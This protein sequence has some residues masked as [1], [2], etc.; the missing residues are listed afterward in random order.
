[1]LNNC[2]NQHQPNAI[3]FSL[4]VIDWEYNRFCS[5]CRV[6]FFVRQALAWRASVVASSTSTSVWSEKRKAPLLSSPR[7]VRLQ[8]YTESLSSL[9]ICVGFSFK[10]FKFFLQSRFK[11][12]S[13]KTLVGAPFQLR[14]RRQTLWAHFIV[15]TITTDCPAT[16]LWKRLVRALQKHQRSSLALTTFCFALHWCGTDPQWL[17]FLL[18][19]EANVIEQNHQ[20]N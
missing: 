20:A 17:R 5:P 18:E 13:Q 8:L 9:A 2:G 15:V 7:S 12:K 10:S 4:Y 1:M 14:L 11:R 3:N 19:L 16:L 6:S